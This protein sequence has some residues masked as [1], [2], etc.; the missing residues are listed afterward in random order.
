MDF[1]LTKLSPRKTVS[2]YIKLAFLFKIHKIREMVKGISKTKLK[3]LN[4]PDYNDKPGT[5]VSML[6]NY[7]SGA[8]LV[9]ILPPSFPGCVEKR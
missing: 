5:P 6:D 1:L 2:K 7:S 3:L 4:L 9:G 8:S